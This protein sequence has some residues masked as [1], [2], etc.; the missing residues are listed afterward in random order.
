MTKFLPGVKISA[1]HGKPRIVDW[2]GKQITVV[3]MF[4]PAAGLRSAEIKR[5]TFNDFQKLPEILDKI[6]EKKEEKRENVKQMTLV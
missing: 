1:V 4:H 6:E 2:K 5:Q 3:H